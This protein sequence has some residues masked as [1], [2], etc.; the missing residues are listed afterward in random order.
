MDDDSP[1]DSSVDFHLVEV[2]M[3][4]VRTF[5]VALEAAFL[6]ADGS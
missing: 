4:L 6:V 1:L 2:C 3:L 5:V